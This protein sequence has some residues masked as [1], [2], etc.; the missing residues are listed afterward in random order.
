MA[1]SA[2]LLEKARVAG[3]RLD[4][5]ERHA[6]SARAEYYAMIR[7][8]HLA[9]S[10]L[11]EI[12]QELEISHQRVQQIVQSAGG[13]WWHRVWRSRNATRNMICTFCDRPADDVSKLI[14]GPGVFICDQCTTHAMQCFEPAVSPAAGDHMK[15]AEAGAKLHCSFC[16][17]RPTASRPLVRSA[18][19]NVCSE[20]AHICG[21]ILLDAAPWR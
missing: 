7:R 6:E 15:R 13:S 5:A 21:Q 11:R 18:K 9:G 14:A 16:S 2:Q 3:S 12:A 17:K 1:I 20:C 8:M 10:P 4:Q 19:A